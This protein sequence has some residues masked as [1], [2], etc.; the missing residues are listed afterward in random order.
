MG[1]SELLCVALLAGTGAAYY[2]DVPPVYV[3]VAMSVVAGLLTYLLIPAAAQLFINARLYGIDLSKST[4][5]VK[6]YDHFFFFFSCT[7]SVMH[8]HFAFVVSCV[9]CAVCVCRR[10]AESMGVIVSA[11]YM[12][13]MFLFIP[14][15]FR[16]WWFNSD[17][18]HHKVLILL[19]FSPFGITVVDDD[20]GDGQ[21]MTVQFEE[22][23][24]ALL[25]I[26][27]MI[28]LGFADD[29]LNL[30]WRHKLILPTMVPFLPLPLQ[31]AHAP[32]HTHTR[33]TLLPH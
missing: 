26:C 24:S 12:G 27:C 33:N 2:Y 4:T 21:W 6:V 9:S 22:F 23:M 8:A 31:H 16:H 28:F 29:V 20:G 13:V 10:R 11:V 19:L 18:P 1:S 32:P 5:D 7:L 30:R 14:F 15:P 17:F 3:S 25:S